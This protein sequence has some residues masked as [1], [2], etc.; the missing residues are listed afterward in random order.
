M[1]NSIELW[2][3]E[4][5]EHTLLA[6]L[7]AGFNLI[8][9]ESN[10]GKTSIIRAIKLAAYNEFD[11]KCIRVGS[12][13]CA[14]EIKTDK[15]RVKVSRPDNHWETQ[16]LGEKTQHF[17][18][19]G[20]EILPEAAEIIG[21]TMVQL[22]D[23]EMPVNV[24]NQLEGHFMLSELNGKSA[25]GSVRAQIIDEI[26]GLSG[27]EGV[28]K[29]VSLDNHRWGREVKQI[30]DRIEELAAQKHD[31][32]VLSVENELL[33]EVKVQL[34]IRRDGKEAVTAMVALCDA[35]V[36]EGGLIENLDKEFNSLPDPVR[37]NIW[38]D[39][40]DAATKAVAEV[41]G[42]ADEWLSVAE[43]VEKVEAELKTEVDT[44]GATSALE[45]VS[46]AFQKASIVKALYDE[47]ERVRG[48]IST[49]TK[50]YNLTEDELVKAMLERDTIESSIKV[51]PLSLRP[52]GPNGCSRAV[53]ETSPAV[54][55][56]VAQLVAAEITPE[57]EVVSPPLEQKSVSNAEI[58]AETDD[59]VGDG[60]FD[61]L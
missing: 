56:T 15:G 29:E 45:A 39:A 53:M 4:S 3:W 43:K 46:E 61:G 31:P 57:K 41:Q 30:E 20:K 42:V 27:I 49:V 7:S 55:D 5:H 47:A 24:M 60:L 38:L 54:T 50:H 58:M 22:G 44:A 32:D 40:A 14:V 12:K 17:E 36:L 8:F 2:N 18:K 16:K 9:G 35:I 51:C 6:D 52:F 48:D 23:I 19:I 33:D 13:D 1:I 11:P 59:D 10:A 25:S 26:S 37:V 28:I 21:L 34:D